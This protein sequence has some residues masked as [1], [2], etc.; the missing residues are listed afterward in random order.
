M[1]KFVPLEKAFLSP[2]KKGILLTIDGAE[3]V[4]STKG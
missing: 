2:S 1:A 3:F 4:G